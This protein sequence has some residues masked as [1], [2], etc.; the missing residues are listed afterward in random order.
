[1]KKL[2]ILR[3]NKRLPTIEKDTMIADIKNVDEKGTGQAAVWREN[4]L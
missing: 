2:L 1:M 4:K 3:R